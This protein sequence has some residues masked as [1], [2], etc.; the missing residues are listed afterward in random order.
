MSYPAVAAVLNHSSASTSARLVLVTI[1]YF[2]SDTGA[3][4]SQETIARMTGLSVRSVKRA[5]KELSELHELDVINDAGDTWGARKT[6]RYYIILECPP[7][8]R[9]DL[10]H[11]KE[12]ADVVSLTPIR[13]SQIVSNL[14]TI[15]DTRGNNR[16][17]IA[18]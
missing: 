13:R 7:D 18:Q 3:W 6:N 9:G 15:G 11:K 4:P 16:G 10:S 1:A 17:Q 12:S 5:I 2:E 8:C 14:V